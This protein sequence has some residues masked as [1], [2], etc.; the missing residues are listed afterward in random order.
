V[1]PMQPLDFAVDIPNKYERQHIRERGNDILGGR[2]PKIE[3]RGKIQ[4]LKGGGAFLPSVWQ[5]KVFKEKPFKKEITKHPA[6]L[7]PEKRLE[8]AKRHQA[9][10]KV[11]VIARDCGVA[12]STVS[13]LGKRLALGGEKSM[14]MKRDKDSR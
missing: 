1:K 4:V 8:I 6:K 10:Q 14:T 5:T 9:G 7:T 11:R 2:K 3:K 12:A 13:M